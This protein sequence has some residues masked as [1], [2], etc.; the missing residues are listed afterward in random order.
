MSEHEDLAKRIAL[1][2]R[3]SRDHVILDTGRC[4]S[5]RGQAAEGVIF[6]LH[7]CGQS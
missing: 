1:A 7:E 6:E 3:G 4:R 2:D 5:A